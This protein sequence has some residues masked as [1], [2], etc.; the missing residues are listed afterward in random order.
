MLQQ[1]LAKGPT[2]RPTRNW[3]WQQD[4]DNEKLDKAMSHEW[5]RPTCDWSINKINV[6]N[7]PNTCAKMT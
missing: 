5:Y 1:T 2:T 4:M 7:G 6:L 3:S